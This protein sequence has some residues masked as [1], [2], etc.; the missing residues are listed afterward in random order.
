MANLATM[1]ATL[2]AGATVLYNDSDAYSFYSFM[3]G[4]TARVPGLNQVQEVQDTIAISGPDLT[5]EFEE[6]IDRYGRTPHL[7]SKAVAKLLVKS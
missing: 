7:N 1:L 2:P 3:N 6:M 4:V 5:G